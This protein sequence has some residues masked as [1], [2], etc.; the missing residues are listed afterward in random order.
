VWTAISGGV[1]RRSARRLRQEAPLVLGSAAHRHE[2]RQSANPQP[3][4]YKQILSVTGDKAATAVDI[5]I[6]NAT[7]APFLAATTDLRWSSA[8]RPTCSST[9]SA[10]AAVPTARIGAGAAVVDDVRYTLGANSE[11]V[12]GQLRVGQL[13]RQRSERLGLDAWK[14]TGKPPAVY[15]HIEQLTSVLYQDICGQKGD[16]HASL[17]PGARNHLAG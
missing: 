16:S 1:G 5:T 9:T 2:L 8:S 7:L 3:T 12:L 6:P 15:H 10:R 14:S 13:D 17:Q 4:L 11:V